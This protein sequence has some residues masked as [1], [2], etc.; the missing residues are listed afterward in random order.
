MAGKKAERRATYEDVL[1]APEHKVAEVI[2]GEMYL[3]PR[4]G[5][6]HAFASSTLGGELQGP[7]GRGRGGPGGW[8]ILDEPELHLGAEPAILVPDLAGWHADRAPMAGAEPFFTVVPDWACEVVSPRTGRLDRIK[9]LPFYA[10]SGVRHAWLLDPLQRTLEV[11]RN[12]AGRWTLLSTHSD[13]DKIRAEPFDAV[14]LEL[15][16]LWSDVQ[17]SP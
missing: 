15:G 10:A 17:T 2:E 3:T 1:R 13:Q 4:P 9:K 16:V 12:E 7:F 5:K 6:P 11:Y 14:E 8:I